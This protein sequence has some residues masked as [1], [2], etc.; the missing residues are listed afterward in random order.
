MRGYDVTR[1]ASCGKHEKHILGVRQGD[2]WAARHR[3]CSKVKLQQV[4]MDSINR[5]AGRRRDYDLSTGVHGQKTKWAGDDNVQNVAAGGGRAVFDAD[6]GRAMRH[7]NFET[8]RAPIPLDE[9]TG[10]D[11]F[12]SGTVLGTVA[13]TGAQFHET[14]R[15]HTPRT[16]S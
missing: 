14:I 7:F 9:V 2:G 3:N 8:S 12:G 5:T 15:S 13:T 10:P 1:C 4:A 6:I 16:F 11:N